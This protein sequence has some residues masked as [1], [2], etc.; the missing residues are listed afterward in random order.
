MVPW[1]R[2]ALTEISKQIHLARK[3][4]NTR[5]KSGT[6]EGIWKANEIDTLLWQANRRLQE[7]RALLKKVEKLEERIKQ[8]KLDDRTNRNTTGRNTMR[9]GG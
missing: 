2:A 4:H 9:A 1:T 6:P 5:T 7:L 8:Q 3:R